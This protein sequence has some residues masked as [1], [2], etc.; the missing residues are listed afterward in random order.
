MSG[1]LHRE[2]EY[3]L[4]NQDEFVAKYD[5]RV[6]ALKDGVVLGD[7]DSAG[8]AMLDL[9]DSHPAWNVPHSKGVAGRQR[10]DGFHPLAFG[11]PITEPPISANAKMTPPC[12]P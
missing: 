4:A 7:F 11:G 1:T 9:Q 5:G 12:Q 8:T 6:I 2:F 10:H 3:Y